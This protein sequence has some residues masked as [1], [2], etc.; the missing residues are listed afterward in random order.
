MAPFQLVVVSVRSDV[1]AGEVHALR[2]YTFSQS[3]KG[4]GFLSS[5]DYHRETV[6]NFLQIVIEKF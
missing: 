4:S 1:K 3:M 6:D 5:T 2:P